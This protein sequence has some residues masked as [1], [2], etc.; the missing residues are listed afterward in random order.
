MPYALYMRNNATGEVK[1]VGV[2][3]TKRT[4]DK[5]KRKIKRALEQRG[6]DHITVHEKK[7]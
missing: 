4:R 3:K 5:V 2:F 6:S 7:V 1:R